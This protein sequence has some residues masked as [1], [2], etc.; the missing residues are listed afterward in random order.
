LNSEHLNIVRSDSIRQHTPADPDPSLRNELVHLLDERRVHD[1]Y[2]DRVA[3]AGDASF[4]RLIPQAV[5]QPNSIEE[6]RRL[7]A[8]SRRRR[9]PM[10]FRAAGT[11]L[12]GQAISSGILVDVS[13]H[14]G[15]I[16]VEDGGELVRVQPGVIGG[17]V[18]RVLKPHGRRIGPDP[19]SIDACMMGGILSNNSS[20]MCC[21]VVENSYRTLHSLRFVLP[22][23]LVLDS[24]SPDARSDLHARAPEI[25]EGLLD[26][27]RRLMEDGAL[28]ER[29]RSKYR[30]KNTTGYSLN[31]FLDYSDP[32]DI[33]THLLIGSEGTLAFIAEG[34]LQTLPDL[35]H[36]YTGLLFF[37]D[38][39][40][41][42]RAIGPLAGSGARAVEI[43]DRPALRCIENLPG[44]PPAI[45]GL[46]AG[47][48]CLLVE[49]QLETSGGLDG[50]RAAAAAA[51]AGLDL[52]EPPRL[53]ADAAEQAVIWKLRKGMIP[54]IGAL[55][56]PG[57]VFIIEDVTFRVQ[58]LAPAIADLQ[59]LFETHGYDEAIIFGH[60]VAGNLHFVIT[61]R[62][63]DEPSVLRYARFMDDLADLVVGK[64]DGALKAEHGTGRNIAPFVEREWGPAAYE[65]MADLKSLIDPDGLLNPGVILNRDPTAHISN[66]KPMPVVEPEI[67]ACIECG[68]C[69]SRC[70]SRTITL[71]PRQRI[72]VRREMVRL[73]ELGDAVLVEELD[74]DYSY[75]GMD[76]CAA[77]GM[78]ATAC[79][80]GIDTGS[81]IKRRRAQSATPSGKRAAVILSRHFAAG[82]WG[83]RVALEM[84]RLVSSA[85]GG[86]AVAA[87]T[88][89]ME[90]AVGQAVPKWN[91]SLPRPM[92]P[93]F[94]GTAQL[95]AEAVYFPTCVSRVMGSAPEGDAGSL[96]QTMVTVAKR[97][98]VRVW[99]PDDCAGLC[100]GMPFESKGYVDAQ[101]EVLSRTVA[102]LWE[103]TDHGR[104]PVVVDASSCAG[105]LHHAA[106][107][108]TG[109]L[110]E[111]LGKLNVLDSVDFVHD[112]LLPQ[113]PL[114]RLDERVVVHPTCA[115]EKAGTTAKLLAIAQACAASA[116]VPLQWGCCGF[117]GDRGLLFPELTAAATRAEA[118]EVTAGGFDGHYSSNLTCETAMTSTTGAR[119]RSILYLVERASREGA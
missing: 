9:V 11:S 57:S 54:A 79:P 10:T 96:M 15:G 101:R 87:L 37:R 1:R 116:T 31:A 80:V 35:P 33:L 78:C 8:L 22:S 4:Y 20:G 110:R 40:A 53:T 14:W 118:A 93:P 73:E 61:P 52:L 84:G 67:A 90:S 94:P 111:Q 83:G 16:E 97:A 119:Y 89:W 66:L 72:V 24:A 56:P 44:A 85:G 64:C 32:L 13:K 48:A 5:V 7:F 109:D 34:V 114:R 6:V 69:E 70:P 86:P 25:V 27:K 30:M 28:S 23:G 17:F 105:A 117:A 2:I 41:A 26:L 49:Y 92:P 42:A 108:L 100:C 115:T 46:S 98:G 77:D 43:M 55:R 39:Q 65:I 29:V 104:L 88:R 18:N 60:A 75:M 113:L 50:A 71:T 3:Y 38:V 74:R 21:G 81:F 82:E 76:T 102:H 99:I 95:G 91:P 58:D 47:A 36:R 103:W 45:G 68:F 12:S 19:A 63:S 51:M 107:G 106:P 62:L 59:R 112:V